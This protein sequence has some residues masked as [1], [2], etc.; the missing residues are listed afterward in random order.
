MPARKASST[1]TAAM[2]HGLS[3][4]FLQQWESLKT[5]VRHQE[6][7]QT[8]SGVPAEARFLCMASSLRDGCKNIARVKRES[9]RAMCRIASRVG[10]ARDLTKIMH[11]NEFW[12]IDYTLT[13]IGPYWKLFAC[14]KRWPCPLPPRQS[15]FPEGTVTLLRLLS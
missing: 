7:D 15:Q 14:T 11:W 8:R 13:I 4:V 2:T 5:N 9:F 1:R 3:F 6:P 10:Q 12:D